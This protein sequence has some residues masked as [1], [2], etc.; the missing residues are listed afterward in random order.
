[1]DHREERGELLRVHA[2]REEVAVDLVDDLP[3]L[4]GPFGE[5]PER[6]FKRLGDRYG[7]VRQRLILAVSLDLRRAKG[8][9]LLRLVS[10][11]ARAGHRHLSFDA[12]KGRYV[13]LQ[14]LPLVFDELRLGRGIRCHDCRGTPDIYLL[15]RLQLQAGEGWRAG[16]RAA[17]IADSL[18]R[19]GVDIAPEDSDTPAGLLF[20]P[21]GEV[22]G[23][24]G[25]DLTPVLTVHAG[26]ADRDR[27]MDETL[28]VITAP[29]APA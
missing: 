3:G 29:A 25:P 21:P 18:R 19:V 17:G 22:T 7:D 26:P 4:P 10:D 24:T 2:E 13:R 28:A 16:R 8:L 11:S 12:I 15:A 27:D 5:Y 20:T 23:G 14:P 6:P 9:G 1:M